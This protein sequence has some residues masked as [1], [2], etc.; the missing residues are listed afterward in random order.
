MT[1]ANNPQG[2][3]AVAATP[4]PA[5]PV[6]TPV[7]SR[8]NDV[9]PRESYNKAWSTWRTKESSLNAR[10]AQLES[11]VETIKSHAAILE[12][13]VNK[14]YNSEELKNA[15]ET[16]RIAKEDAAKVVTEA[17][18]ELGL[19]RNERKSAY[20]KKIMNV[21]LGLGLNEVDLLKLGSTAEIA[22]FVQNQVVEKG[23]YPTA[24][25]PSG[26]VPVPPP[27]SEVNL[28]LPPPPPEVSTAAEIPWSKKSPEERVNI[29]L[30]E[31]IK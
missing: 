23:F 14:P 20:V 1:V 25:I 24:P 5:Q 21:Y 18:K 11:E 7:A 8:T 6:T 13:E 2:S 19:V 31:K 17:N 3:T 4:V 27:V 16:I 12:A 9:I 10:I 26:D 28:P 15:A 22:E 30:K 29:G